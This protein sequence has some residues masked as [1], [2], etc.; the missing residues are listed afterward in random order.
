MFVTLPIR[1][2]LLPHDLTRVVVLLRTIPHTG[3]VFVP[4]QDIA[5]VI[6]QQHAL[7][8]VGGILLSELIMV[9]Q[10]Q[11]DQIAAIL[12]VKQQQN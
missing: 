7:G 3:I 6:R 2:V 4:H 5:F 11:S 1:I 12:L 10:F 9:Q 8:C